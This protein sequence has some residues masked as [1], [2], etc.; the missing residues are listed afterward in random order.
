MRRRTAVTKPD[1]QAE[2]L[3]CGFR[4]YGVNGQGLAAQHADR[5][6]HWVR[7]EVS[8]AVNYN[9]RWENT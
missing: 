6:G 9:A 8:R 1:I 5:T 2:C 4:Q 3:D 7:V